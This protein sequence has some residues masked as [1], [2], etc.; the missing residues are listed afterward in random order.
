MSTSHINRG[1]LAPLLIKLSLPVLAGQ[2]FNLFYNLVDT[3]FIAAIDPRDPWLLGATGL[4]FPIFFLFMALTFGISGGVAS[5][6][7]RAIGAG[8]SQDLDRTAE[9][10]LVLAL[11]LA[12]GLMAL[13]Y[14]LAPVLVTLFGGQGP[15]AAYAQEYLFWN[16]PSVPFMLLGGV[17]TGILQGEGRTTHLM[18][19][20]IIGAVINI[21]LDP[22]LIFSAGMGIGGAG[23]A[24][25]IGNASSF[26]Y[27]LAVF[28]RSQREVKIHW[29]LA[30][31]SLPVIGEI[32]RVGTPQ[33]LSNILASLSFIFYN[34][35]MT[36]I[37]PIILSSFTL[38]SRLEQMALMPVWAL[39]SGLGTIAGQAAGAHDL[40]RMDRS[41]RT[42]TFMGL[43][44]S[45]VFF[46]IFAALSQSLFRL[47]QEDPRVLAT[48]GTIFPYMSLASF[49]SIPIFMTG[50]VMAVSGFA[51]RSL[52]L[53]AARI[54]LLNIPSAALALYVFKAELPG[55][56]MAILISSFLALGLN[57]LVHQDFFRSL[58]KG[59][60]TIRTSVA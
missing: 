29:K 41:W 24:T 31:I 53:S 49:I 13:L 57:L 7:A 59:K 20:M 45:G 56:L 16:L 44:V 52:A 32:V 43:L 10:A 51:Q 48:A 6:V 17:F 35:I 58:Q 9:S 18:V 15:M 39:T 27:L 25:V 37:D 5:L 12:L 11:G 3:Y 19:S 55:I 47:F 50:T 23:L 33:S 42:T 54:Y 4:V 1:P 28:I 46:L 60:L 2:V 22:I 40:G 8:K 21:I 34:R 14:P 30:H 26:V 38:Y 36:E